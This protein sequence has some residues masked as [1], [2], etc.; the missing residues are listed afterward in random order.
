[1][2][3]NNNIDRLLQMIDHPEDYTEQEILDVINHDDET[4]E[5]YR[6]LVL[7]RRAGRHHRME[8]QPVDV[9]AA[10]R[11]FEQ[12]HFEKPRRRSLW[13]K[14]AAALAGIL[15]MSGLTWA[16]VLAV[17]H[18][19]ST[20]Q[21]KPRTE[22][23]APVQVDSIGPRLGV[24]ETGVPD[25][26]EP[27]VFENVPLDQMIGEI[28]AHYGMSVE[29]KNEEARNLRFHFV[30]NRDDGLDKV[31]EDI[32]Y[33]ESVDIRQDNDRLIVQ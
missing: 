14:V 31:L 1:M 16:A 26:V 19:T 24:A 27:V 23:V 7:A 25:N 11:Q 5:T 20:G 22:D 4:R 17:R 30:W 15:L 33:F 21:S 32:N 13:P 12:A 9:D 6:Q 28:A 2:E 8:N 3:Q 10:W 18:V 29:F